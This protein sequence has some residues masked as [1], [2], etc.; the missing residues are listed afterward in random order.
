MP[1]V[2]HRAVRERGTLG[3]SLAHADPAAE[4]PACAVALDAELLLRARGGPRTVAAAQFFR[5]VLDTDR[6]PGELLCAAHFPVARPDQVSGFAELS[7][8]HGDFAIVGVA[9]AGRLTRGTPGG[10]RL[11]VFGCETHPRVSAAAAA[12]LD[13]QAW[14]AP[15]ADAVAAAVADELDPMDDQNGTAVTK[16]R[17]A[18]VLVRRVLQQMYGGPGDA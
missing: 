12:L 13:G 7:R 3:G 15:L 11:V 16:R 2:A 10:V 9:A 14:S 18:R 4:L 6:R 5:G 17:Q 8:R 1:H